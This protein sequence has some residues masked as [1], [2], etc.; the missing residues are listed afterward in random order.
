MRTF[1]YY[2]GENTYLV[3]ATDPNPE[4]T[5]MRETLKRLRAGETVEVE[6]IPVRMIGE[7]DHL[8]PGDLYVGERNEGGKLLNVLEVNHTFRWVASQQTAY[9]Y[10]LHECVKVEAII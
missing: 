2:R 3:F 4:V 10:D 7:S 1:I 9:S 6:G 8:H 5:I